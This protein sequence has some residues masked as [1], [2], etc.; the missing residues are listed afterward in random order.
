MPRAS[1]I[2]VRG[3][4]GQV[5]MGFVEVAADAGHRRAEVIA[6]VTGAESDVGCFLEV[7]GPAKVYVD[8]PG[9]AAE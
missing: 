6:A 4:D 5:V 3:P 1:G 7:L 9:L 8:A 2:R